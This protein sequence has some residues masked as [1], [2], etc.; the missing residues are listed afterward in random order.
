MKTF[1][2]IAASM[3]LLSG[4]AAA[5]DKT[6]SVS[7]LTSTRTVLHVVTETHYSSTEIETST[8]LIP[9]PVVATSATNT[10]VT[11]PIVY[12]AGNSSTPI[13]TGGFTSSAKATG[14][15]AASASGSSSPSS[16]PATGAASSLRIDAA[17][18]A[19]V[20]GAGYLLL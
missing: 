5:D 15:A 11:T 2:L 10:P 16:T 19:V 14:S 4:L 13:G 3:A 1:S 7:T 17:V 18:A 9:T 6:T 8:E 12:S 20:A